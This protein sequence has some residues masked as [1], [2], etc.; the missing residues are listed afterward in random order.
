MR[1][2]AGTTTVPCCACSPGTIK[3][4]ASHCDIHCCDRVL[5]I[6]VQAQADDT[7]YLGHDC[8]VSACDAFSIITAA[9]GKSECSLRTITVP[10]GGS[11]KA[12]QFWITGAAAGDKAEWAVI[13]D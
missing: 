11:I 6:T 1:F 5:V 9:C 2:R 13:L 3:L 4:L 8:G 7:I 12:D 10:Q